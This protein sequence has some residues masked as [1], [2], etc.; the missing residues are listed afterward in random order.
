MA[1]SITG[2]SAKMEETEKGNTSIFALFPVML[3]AMLT[4]LMIQLQS[5]SRLVLVFLTAP[6][7]IIGASLGLNL[8]NQPFGFVALLGL[9]AL[10]G[11]I[12]RNAVILV[13]Q[14]ESD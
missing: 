7:G 1:I 4:L 3:I 9:I 5:L 12:M 8:A 11:M 6:L 2:N 14:I 13:D 10:A